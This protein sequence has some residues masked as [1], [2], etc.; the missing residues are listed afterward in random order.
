MKIEAV[1]KSNVTDQVYKQML[2][3]I[4]D[5]TWSPGTKIPSENELKEIFQVSRNTVRLVLNRLCM[6]GL[7]ETYHGE[8]TFVKK[9]GPSIY[10][11]S[12]IPPICLEKHDFIEIMEFRRGIEVE[13][14]RLAAARAS[15]QHI[16][17]L[18]RILLI[19]EDYKNDAVNYAKADADF[20]IAI[21]K[22]SGNKMLEQMMSIIKEI[23]LPNLE[24]VIKAQGNSDGR[25]FH[26]KIFEA[27]Q[28]RDTDKA[29]YS[30]EH[31]LT[32]VIERFKKLR[33]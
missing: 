20:H 13:T 32:V 1:S 5:G 19:S 29:V 26:P 31:H 10:V 12:L 11:N 16:N 17:D 2:D 14:T 24:S 6:L 33:T 27:I 21:A 3:N 9:L 8:G 15:E 22:A 23:L 28:N 18:E 30:M 7:L 25:E 4:S